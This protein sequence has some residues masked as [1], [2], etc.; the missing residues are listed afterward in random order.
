MPEERPEE[1]R[2][3]RRQDAAEDAA[4][5]SPEDGPADG[6]VAGAP[7]SPGSGDARGSSHAGPAYRCDL[8]GAAM[9]ERHC[10]LVCPACG[11][12]RDCSDP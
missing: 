2:E 3:Q 10:K 6:E 5:A 8:C 9:L 7:I 11:Y 12:Q 1:R 4:G